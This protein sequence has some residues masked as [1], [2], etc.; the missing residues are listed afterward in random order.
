MQEPIKNEHTVNEKEHKNEIK[1]N[2]DMDLV[3][4]R[5]L[6]MDIGI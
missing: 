2:I 3:W 1:M 4:I 6:G 5:T